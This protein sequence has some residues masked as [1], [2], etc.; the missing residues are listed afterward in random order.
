MAGRKVWPP[1]RPRL[2]IVSEATWSTMPIVSC[3]EATQWMGV[4]LLGLDIMRRAGR[5]GGARGHL[6]EALGAITN[7]GRRLRA[8]QSK[9]GAKEDA[10]SDLGPESEY[11]RTLLPLAQPECLR[12]WAI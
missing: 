11:L 9:R 1:G 6:G 2:R 8:L 4:Y 3:D 10:M 12:S 5:I 7:T